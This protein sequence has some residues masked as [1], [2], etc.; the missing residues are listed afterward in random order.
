MQQGLTQIAVN[1]KQRCGE[2]GER[3][4]PVRAFQPQT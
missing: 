2:T 1:G 4:Q 3:G